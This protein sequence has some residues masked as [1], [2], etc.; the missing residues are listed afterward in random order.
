MQE[1]HISLIKL[2]ELMSK[3]PS[4]FYRLRPVSIS[5]GNKADIVIFGEDEEWIVDNYVSK[6]AN[7]P[8]TGW[9]LPGKIHYTICDGKIV[10]KA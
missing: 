2:M 6:S 1:G 9:K 8:F 5:E 10:Y 4:E 3:N 7:S